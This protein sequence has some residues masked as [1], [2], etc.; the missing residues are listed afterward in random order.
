MHIYIGNPTIIG[1]DNGSSPDRCKTIIWTNAEIL[2][3]RPLETNFKDIL[4]R[5]HTF[6]FQKMHLKI[7][8]AKWWPFCLCRNVLTHLNVLEALTVFCPI[9]DYTRNTWQLELEAVH[10]I[11]FFVDR[12][13]DVKTRIQSSQQINTVPLGRHRFHHEWLIKTIYVMEKSCK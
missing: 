4:F 13:G 2:L 3:I 6:S 8:P 11:L 9:T 12:Q 5:I 1:L 7:L 10:S